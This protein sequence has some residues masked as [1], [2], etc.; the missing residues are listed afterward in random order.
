VAPRWR[1]AVRAAALIDSNRRTAV[2]DEAPSKK[3]F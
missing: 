2:G 1:R 3:L